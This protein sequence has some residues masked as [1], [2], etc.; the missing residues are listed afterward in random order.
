MRG[1]ITKFRVGGQAKHISLPR[2]RKRSKHNCIEALGE[3]AAHCEVCF[4]RCI[5]GVRR[6]ADSDSSTEI[7]R[8]TSGCFGETEEGLLISWKSTSEVEYIAL[9]AAE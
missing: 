6:I 7:R 2:Q 4:R 5:K 3:L 8:S 1:G 9:T